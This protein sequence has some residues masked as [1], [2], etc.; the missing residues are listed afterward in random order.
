MTHYRL[1]AAAMNTENM[2]RA[3]EERFCRMTPDYILLYRKTKPRNIPCVEIQ[4][5]DGGRLTEPDRAWL[6]D[7][8]MSLLARRAAQG[9]R[10]TEQKLR[11]MLDALE[12]ALA[13]E[14]E[15]LDKETAHGEDKPDK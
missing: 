14:Q 5:E 10:E 2:A 12:T 13:E 11:K 9:H 4:R 6:K 3:A 15:K 8:M 1:F 7:C